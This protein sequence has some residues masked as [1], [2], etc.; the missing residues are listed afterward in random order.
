MQTKM[1]RQC[2]REFAATN[3]CYAERGLCDYSSAPLVEVPRDFRSSEL[4][5]MTSTEFEIRATHKLLN[6][7][8]TLTTGAM[9]HE[10]TLSCSDKDA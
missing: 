7:C 5:G 4:C 10:F 1:C 8:L 9:N 3:P 6:P 2:Q